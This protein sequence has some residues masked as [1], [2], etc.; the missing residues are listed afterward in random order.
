MS[1]VTQTIDGGARGKVA[2]VTGAGSGIGRAIALRLARGGTAIAALDRSSTDAAQV[3]AEIGAEGGRALALTADVMDAG[4]VD[5][6]VEMA[7]TELGGLDILVTSAGL[8]RSVSLLEMT[9]EVWNLV[10]GVNLTG[11]FHCLR[12][13]V[14]H[15][16]RQGGGRIIM[17]GSTCAQRGFSYRSAYCASKGGVISLMQAASVE[18]AEHGVTV[19]TVSPGPVESPMTRANHTPA[20]RAAIARATP[21]RRYGQPEEV[22]GCVA[23]L[24]SEEA[25]YVT[26]QELTVDGGFAAAGIIYRD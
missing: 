13:V 10:L 21:M 15:L 4:Q 22:A 11:T 16:V 20:I 7:V 8:S 24:A 12:A 2:L 14:P 19:N 26:G 1:A 9:P 18:L 23:Y 6:A 3:A 5:A 25:A 17:I